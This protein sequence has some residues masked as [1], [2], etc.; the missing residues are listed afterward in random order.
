M[1]LVRARAANGIATPSTALL[2]FRSAF[3]S[4]GQTRP[5]GPNGPSGPSGQ[6]RPLKLGHCSLNVNVGSWALTVGRA[7]W[8]DL[9]YAMHKDCRY[10]VTL[11]LNLDV[12]SLH[13]SFRLECNM[14][15]EI[16]LKIWYE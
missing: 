9:G 13:L 8:V 3:C 5:N 15:F 4:I 12:E 14:Y 16:F 11:N 2:A 10:K 6:I 1:T 7:S